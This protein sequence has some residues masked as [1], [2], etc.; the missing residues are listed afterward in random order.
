MNARPVI[1]SSV[2][3]LVVGVGACRSLPN[4]VETDPAARTQAAPRE[5]WEDKVTENSQQLMAEGKKIFRYDTFG[6]EAFWGD[7]LQ[8]H[9]AILREKKGGVGAGL[10]PRQALQLGLKVGCRQGPETAGRS[11]EGRCESASTTRTRRWSCSAPT[12]SSA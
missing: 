3:L 11:A 5:E 2:A 8:L 6:S 12:R 10:T 4:D 1:A 9:K 7:Q